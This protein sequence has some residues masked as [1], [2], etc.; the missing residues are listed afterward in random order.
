M[1]VPSLMD[2]RSCLIKCPVCL[3]VH[4]VEDSSVASAAL[5]QPPASRRCSHG[6]TRVFGAVG[7]VC[8]VCL[9]TE[10]ESGRGMVALACGKRRCAA[11]LIM[12]ASRAAALG[13]PVKASCKSTGRHGVRSV[14]FVVQNRRSVI[15][16]T[17]AK[18]QSQTWARPPQP[19]TCFGAS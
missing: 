17:K 4:E 12:C 2:E 9:S 19:G 6:A 11:S 18:R 7:A 5:Y 1:R 8:P 3:A 13:R 14:S 15:R 16:S 10:S